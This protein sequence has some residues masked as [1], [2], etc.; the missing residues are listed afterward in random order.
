MAQQQPDFAFGGSSSTISSLFRC[1]PALLELACSAFLFFA[2][3]PAQP[4][5]NEV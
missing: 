4:D 2:T 5:Q 1:G 3:T